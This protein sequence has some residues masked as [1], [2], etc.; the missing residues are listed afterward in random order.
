MASGEDTSGL[1]D[2]DLSELSDGDKPKMSD[3]REILLDEPKWRWLDEPKWR[4]LSEEEKQNKKHL[5]CPEE[6]IHN[7]ELKN[8]RLE[9]HIKQL[10]CENSRLEDDNSKMKKLHQ[11]KEGVVLRTKQLGK[12]CFLYYWLHSDC[13]VSL[14]TPARTYISIHPPDTTGFH[15]HQPNVVQSLEEDIKRLGNPTEIMPLVGLNVDEI[16]E[17]YKTIGVH[18]E[19]WTDYYRMLETALVKGSDDFKNYLAKH[20][21]SIPNKMCPLYIYSAAWEHTLTNCDSSRWHND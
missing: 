21:P 6:T 3:K 4:W 11:R 8:W 12:Y 1:S 5:Q 19:Q 15:S 7:L 2:K 14:E 18:F 9:A 20:K 16:D 13:H 10:T 17:W